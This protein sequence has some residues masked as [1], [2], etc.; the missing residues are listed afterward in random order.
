M[1]SVRKKDSSSAD[2]WG[3]TNAGLAVTSARLVL[4]ETKKFKR[5]KQSGSYCC[6]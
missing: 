6:R 3:D 5:E 4:R 2:F 1:A